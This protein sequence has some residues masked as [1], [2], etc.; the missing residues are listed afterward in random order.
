[1]QKITPRGIICEVW[2]KAGLLL[3]IRFMV[4]YGIISKNGGS[5]TYPHDQP[6]LSSRARLA[7]RIDMGGI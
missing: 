5:E 2:P 6:R 4:I 1:M 3:Q 7:T